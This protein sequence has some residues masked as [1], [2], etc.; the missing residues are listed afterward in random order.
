ML[1]TQSKEK[2]IKKYGNQNSQKKKQRK[3]KNSNQNSQKKKIG[4]TNDIDVAYGIGN[5]SLFI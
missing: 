3:I 1:G 4:V 2:E 5:F